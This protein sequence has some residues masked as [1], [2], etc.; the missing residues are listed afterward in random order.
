MTHVRHGQPAYDD[1][2]MTSGA[3]GRTHIVTADAFAE[4]IW[5]G[6]GRYYAICGVD[7]LVAALVSEPGDLCRACARITAHK[8]AHTAPQHRR[9]TRWLRQLGRSTKR[10]G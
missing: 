2:E 6:Q 3:D 5:N 8:I 4:G 7:V 9:I 10:H 1:L